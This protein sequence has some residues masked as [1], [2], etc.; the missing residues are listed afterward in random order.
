M[1]AWVSRFRAVT[2]PSLVRLR[3]KVSSAN[4]L[5]RIMN[6][7]R[8]EAVIQMATLMGA[9]VLGP[10][11]LG[12]TFEKQKGGAASGFAA[13][14]IA[15][16]DEI[17]ETIIPATDV[18][19]AKAVQIGAFMAMMIDDCYEQGD[20]VVFKNGLHTLATR[21]EQRFGEPFVTG[22]PGN[23]IAF[24]NELDREQKATMNR[25]GEGPHYFRVMKELTILG[26]FTSEIGCTQ[27]LRLMEVPGRYDGCAPYQRGDRAW[28]T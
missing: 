17:G 9:T 6:L 4:Q 23:R 11:L 3:P 5:L 24:L 21:Y 20:Q 8:R 27:A 16:L 25:R 28:A 7:N 1:S 14:D 2:L 26:Y 18:P 10:R 19:G 15:L 22:S 12:A 13:K